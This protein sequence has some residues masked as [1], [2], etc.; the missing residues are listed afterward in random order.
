VTDRGEP[1][2]ELVAA[3]A[4]RDP[5][6]IRAALEQARLLVAVVALP[7]V[8]HASEGEMALALL[9]SADGAQALPAFTGLAALTAWRPDAR[10]VPR[11]AGEVIAYAVAEHMPVVLDP[12]SPHAW[13]LHPDATPACTAPTW[14]PDRRLRKAARHAVHR[15][16]AVDAG[17]PVLAIVCP[18][19]TLDARWAEQLQ[20][21]APQAQL[22]VV[23]GTAEADIR[24]VGV[25]LA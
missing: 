16:Y 6:R 4:A 20:A 11:P 7:G 23:P 14:K 1:D 10:P 18:D 24:R 25:P 9:E 12:G 13:T 21:Q 22:M 15:V 3:L 8:E 2:A 19:G 5:E 17:G